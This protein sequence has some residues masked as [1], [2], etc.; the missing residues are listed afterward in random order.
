MAELTSS[1]TNIFGPALGGVLL[2]LGKLVALDTRWRSLQWP[3]TPQ[4]PIDEAYAESLAMAQQTFEDTAA[5]KD[6]ELDG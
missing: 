4:G 5:G 6:I 2:S 3:D 1:V